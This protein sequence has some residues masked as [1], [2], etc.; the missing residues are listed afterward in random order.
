MS[1]FCRRLDK[2]WQWTGT[3]SGGIGEYVEPTGYTNKITEVE[4]ILVHTGAC[5]CM[6]GT[7]CPW[8]TSV[9]FQSCRFFRSCWSEPFFLANVIPSLG[10][11]AKAK[12]I[13]YSCLPAA[14]IPDPTNSKI[15]LWSLI[16][17]RDVEGCLC[18]WALA[19]YAGIYFALGICVHGNN[20]I[21]SKFVV[22][23]T[24][25]VTK[26]RNLFW[27]RLLTKSYLTHLV[28]TRCP[29]HAAIHF[30]QGHQLAGAGESRITDTEESRCL[31]LPHV[32]VNLG[33]IVWSVVSLPGVDAVSGSIVQNETR[34][35]ST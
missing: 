8:T 28:V 27:P 23:V 15:L 11:L 18:H 25:C 2:R 30:G 14:W 21:R 3:T 19:P 26:R 9:I 20:V 7:S 32:L 35:V 5:C 34:E 6:V 1:R 13:L 29:C 33:S 10:E 16:E 4:Y 31:P 17:S 22:K 12:N 24:F